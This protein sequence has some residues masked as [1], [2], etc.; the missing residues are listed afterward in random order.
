MAFEV[1]FYADNYSGT[2]GTNPVV[3]VDANTGRVLKQWEGLKRVDAT[4]P[5]GNE[6]TGIYYYGPSLGFL[7]VT[8]SGGSCTLETPYVKTV[9]MNNTTDL[10]AAGI[11]TAFAFSCA[12]NQTPNNTVKVT[13]GAYSPLNDAHYFARVVYDM[14]LAYVGST[15]LPSSHKIDLR[16]HYG[17]AGESAAWVPV[18]KLIQIGDGNAVRFPLTSLDVV[19]HEISHGF[20]QFNAGI[21]TGEGEPAA[22]NE[23]FSDMAGEAAEYFRDGT[24]DFLLGAQVVKSAGGFI[25]SLSNPSVGHASNYDPDNTDNHTGA[26]I[27]GKAFYLLANKPGWNTEKA[28]RVFGLANKRY[29][30]PTVDFNFGACGVEIAATDAGYAKADVTSAFASVGVS[31]NTLLWDTATAL[32]LYNGPVP[33][34]SFNTRAISTGEE[35]PN[36]EFGIAARGNI[37][38][39]SGKYYAE[40]TFDNQSAAMEYGYSGTI[41]LSLRRQD[42]A[43]EGNA[44][45]LG[46]WS[47]AWSAPIYSSPHANGPPWFRSDGFVLWDSSGPLSS[48]RVSEG[49]TI[50]IAVDLDNGKIWYS[51][52]GVW[53]GD[54]GSGI[55]PAFDESLYDIDKKIS[56]QSVTP[57]LYADFQNVEVLIRA[58]DTDK[59]F[60]PPTGFDWWGD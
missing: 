60:D 27:Y 33:I 32:G 4:G 13:N 29:W 53:E 46:D 49:D 28:F 59:L 41:S 42:V 47:I 8:S 10:T 54:P 19:A 37:Y 2:A 44:G 38:R 14:Y 25:R 57:H 21:V 17:S 50:G 58:R 35:P 24:N 18:S 3:L 45:M 1:T 22:I 11:N 31:C 26:G 23:A 39:N 52:N 12:L 55:S 43:V 15:P 5:G 34:F 16:V 36:G 56:G 9:H 20:S 51:L 30:T 40:F 48:W 6:K 7:D